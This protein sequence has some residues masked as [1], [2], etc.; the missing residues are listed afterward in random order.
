MAQATRIRYISVEGK[1]ITGEYL[2]GDSLYRGV[3]AIDTR[4]VSVEQKV[5]GE[6]K[7]VKVTDYMTLFQAKKFV[8]DT[9]KSMGVLFYDEVRRKKIVQ[10][11]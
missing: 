3:I 4:T 9:L 11:V 8:R 7:A 6:Y 10:S 5:D 2:V 1:L